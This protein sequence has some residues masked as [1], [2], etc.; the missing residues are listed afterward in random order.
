MKNGLNDGAIAYHLKEGI[1]KKNIFF[2]VNI[3]LMLDNGNFNYQD[4]NLFFYSLKLSLKK[5]SKT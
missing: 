1:L 4:L 2:V 3:F 5:E